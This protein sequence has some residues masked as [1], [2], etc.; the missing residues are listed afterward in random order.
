MA[1]KSGKPKS[2][3]HKRKLSIAY[4]KRQA[5]KEKGIHL[6]TR[7]EEREAARLAKEPI[8]AQDVCSLINEMAGSNITTTCNDDPTVYVIGAKPPI[9]NPI[10]FHNTCQKPPGQ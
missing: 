10:R 9:K 8:F 3:E 1:K 4:H 5:A 6:P 2:E 7:K